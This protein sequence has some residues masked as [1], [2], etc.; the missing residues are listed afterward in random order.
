VKP[1]LPFARPKLSIAQVV[2]HL[3]MPF[4]LHFELSSILQ[5]PFTSPHFV[6]FPKP[7][8]AI[9][10]FAHLVASPTQLAS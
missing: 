6:S 2:Q 5:R 9:S 4:S 7:L 1:Q 8:T 10:S 3:P